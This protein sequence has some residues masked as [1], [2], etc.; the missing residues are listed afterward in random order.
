MAR[1]P[2]YLAIDQGTHATRA[3]VLSR[4]GETLASALRPVALATPLPGRAEQDPEALLQ[5]VVEVLDTLAQALGP[6]RAA[7]VRSAG[8][9][10]QRATLVCWD[11]RTGVPLTPAL[12][13]QDTRAA[14]LLSGLQADTAEIQARTGLRLSPHYGASKLRWCLEHVPEVRLA[15][16]AGRLTCGPLASFLL[17]R[18][19]AHRPRLVDPGNASRTLLWNPATRDWDPWLL[20]RFGVPRAILPASVPSRHPD[21]TLDFGGR[22]LPVALVMGDQPAALLANGAAAGSAFVNLGTG[23]FILCPAPKRAIDAA[24]PPTLLQTTLMADRKHATLA[25]EGTVNGAGSAL[26]AFAAASGIP[27]LAERLPAWLASHTEPPLYLNGIGGVG[28]PL[29]QP[30]FASRFTADAPPEAQ[31]VAVVESIVFLVAWNLEL[32]RATPGV[33]VSSLVASGGLSTLDGLCQR[34]ADLVGLP[35]LH[36]PNHEATTRGLAYLLA[37]APADWRVGEPARFE[38]HPDT[39]LERRY[40]A[41]RAAMLAQVGVGEAPT[42]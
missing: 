38:P 6:E 12:S 8:L 16:A 18:L 1:P 40:A 32:M 30:H 31:A 3:A 4:S 14:E 33:T 13:W 5:S 26:A 36:H 37:D 2:L 27:D 41:W 23:A 9:A 39:A 11:H 25:L 28:S 42:Q 17:A 7:R 22:Q 29:W 24:A 35:V 10:T 21:G 20:T 15:G 19:L 34:L